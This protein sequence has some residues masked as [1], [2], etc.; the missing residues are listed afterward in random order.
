MDGGRG[1]KGLFACLSLKHRRRQ[2]AEA[3]AH[4]RME[5]KRRRTRAKRGRKE[6]GRE[7]GS[8]WLASV[9]T[10]G[11][12]ISRRRCSTPTSSASKAPTEDG[13]CSKVRWISLPSWIGGREGG[14]EGATDGECVRLHSIPGNLPC[15][16]RG[17]THCPLHPSL[18]PSLPPSLTPSTSSL[19]L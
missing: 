5:D 13:T 1:R 14:R 19:L 12:L 8:T 3:V 9:D 6:G 7:G 16:Y 11:S 17:N 4:F 18:P 10:E 2:Q 15:F